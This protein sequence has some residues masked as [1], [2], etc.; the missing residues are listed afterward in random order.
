MCIVKKC[1]EILLQDAQQFCYE[2][3][4]VTKCADI[5]LRNAR[6][7]KMRRS[8]VTKCACHYIMADDTKCSLTGT[9]S[10]DEL[11]R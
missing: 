6:R 4:D 5:L 9:V 11:Y 10:K 1:A 2:M 7:Y 8:F 3:R